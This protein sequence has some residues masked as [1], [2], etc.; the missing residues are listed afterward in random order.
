MSNSQN[1]RKR[2]G[3]LAYYVTQQK[4]TEK[5]Y[6]GEYNN[7]FPKGGYYSCVVCETPLF[8]STHKFES[9]CGWPA[10][11]A[12]L[13]DK[14]KGNIDLQFFLFILAFCYL[15]FWGLGEEIRNLFFFGT[16]IKLGC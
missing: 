11:N 6:S 9:H 2:L 16:I 4:G 15:I 7:H 8:T 1:L 14:I 10:F 12:S 3:D 13:S 5:P